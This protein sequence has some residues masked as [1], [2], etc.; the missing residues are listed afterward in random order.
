MTPSSSTGVVSGNYISAIGSGNDTSDLLDAGGQHLHH[1]VL[2]VRLLFSINLRS[3]ASE[4]GQLDDTLTFAGCDLHPR[5]T[6]AMTMVFNA[7]FS[8]NAILGCLNFGGSWSRL[9]GLQRQHFCSGQFLRW[10]W[11]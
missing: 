7:T 10:C 3:A 4:G 9:T 5:L 2:A 11:S 6:S 8:V 1:S